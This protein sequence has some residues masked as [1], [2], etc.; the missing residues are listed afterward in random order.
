KRVR[1]SHPTENPQVQ[2]D[3]K[4]LLN[5]IQGGSRIPLRW[6][7]NEQRQKANPSVRAGVIPLLWRGGNE[8][9]RVVSMAKK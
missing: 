1:F 6:N 9:D 2:G 5:R 7:A 3:K 8:V 4:P